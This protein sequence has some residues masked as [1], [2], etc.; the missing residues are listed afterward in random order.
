MK[1]TLKAMGAL[2]TVFAL[3]AAW[4]T[5]APVASAATLTQITN[6]GTNPT[7]INMFLYVPDKVVAKPPILVVAHYCGGSAAAMYSGT[8]FAS[9]AN[10]YGFI[11]IY[12][13]VTRSSK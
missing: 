6:F 3:V 9:L 11:A 13:E 2:A 7:N 8:E 1:L 12:P 4:L 10:Q 5:F